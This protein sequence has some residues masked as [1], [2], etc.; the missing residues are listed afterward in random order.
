MRIVVIGAGECGVRAALALRE[1]GFDGAIDLVHGEAHVPYERPPLSKLAADGVYLKPINGADIILTANIGVHRDVTALAIDRHFK[2]VELSNSE[3]LPYD[4]L[5]IVTGAR[6][7]LLHINDTPVQGVRYLRTYDDARSLFE[8]VSPDCRLSIIGGGFIGLEVAAAARKRGAAVT[9][10]EGTPRILSRAVPASLA[11]KIETRHR[12]EGVK[13]NIG[14][15]I[16]AISAARLITLT[17]GENI[18]SD[19]ILA[20]IGSL[21]NVELAAAAGLVIENGIAVNGTLQT[22]DPDIYAAG[23]CCSFPH[24]L[25]GNKR[26]R[27]ES[28]RAAQE[29]GEHVLR[30]YLD[31][32]NPI[33]PCHG[34]GQINMI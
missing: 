12:A 30:R 16:S 13:F 29:Q 7:R 26:I 4:R 11:A 27:I 32:L 10:I 14:T 15:T 25:Y 22:S 3:R 17:D 1:N 28:W 9:V 19:V 31:Q 24:P 2:E 20:G 21:P 5:L 23:D 34:S 18:D 33:A 6:P 8:M